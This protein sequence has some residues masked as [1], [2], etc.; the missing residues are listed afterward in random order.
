M[1]GSATGLENAEPVAASVLDGDVKL[2]P[3][4]REILGETISNIIQETVHK[5]IVLTARS[6]TIALPPRTPTNG[7]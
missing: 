4:L 5:E 3:I 7:Q 2:A 6:R 1:E